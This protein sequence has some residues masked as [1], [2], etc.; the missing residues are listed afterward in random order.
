MGRPLRGALVGYGFIAE[1]GHSPEY[2]RLAATSEAE[3]HAIADVTEARRDLSHEEP[4]EGADS[5][6]ATTSSWRAKPDGSTSSTSRRHPT[7]T[8]KSP[9]QR[10]R[11]GFTYSAKSPLAVSPR[12]A[13]SMA[14]LAESEKRVLFPCHNYRH[15][16]VVEEVRSILRK[17]VIGPVRL[18]TLQTFRTTQRAWGCRVAPRLAPRARFSPA[19]GIAMDHGSHTFYL[20][21]EWLRSYPTS[22][23]RQDGR[24]R[25][26]RH[27]R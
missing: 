12:E 13:M 22:G 6:G 24:L 23:D 11:T 5:T 25:W 3:I 8:L 15:A 18:A 4:S 21:F 20:A 7:R 19:A 17:D 1:H 2:R 27:G 9:G 10:S 16:P 26:S 14:E